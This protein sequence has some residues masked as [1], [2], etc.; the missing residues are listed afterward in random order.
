MGIVVGEQGLG[1]WFFDVGLLDFDGWGDE[2]EVY[3]L[4]LVG[5]K[6][7]E[8][9]PCVGHTRVIGCLVVRVTQF[10]SFAF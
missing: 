2:D 5:R 1:S 4:A 3:L 8:L 10:D 6:L 7:A 9:V